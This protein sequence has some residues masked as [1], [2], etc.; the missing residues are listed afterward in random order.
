ME[1]GKTARQ[2]RGTDDAG[3]LRETLFLDVPYLLDSLFRWTE[4]RGN[5][6]GSVDLVDPRRPFVRQSVH[7]WPFFWLCALVALFV[8]YGP[9]FDSLCALV[10][11]KGFGAIQIVLLVGLYALISWMVVFLAASLLTRLT[12]RLRQ[13]PALFDA[14]DR[15][16]SFEMG[17]LPKRVLSAARSSARRSILTRTQVDRILLVLP[18][19]ATLATAMNERGRKRLA[20]GLIAAFGIVAA[21]VAP[22]GAAFWFMADSQPDTFAC[23]A[24]DGGGTA[25]V[26]QLMAW[27]LCVGAAAFCLSRRPWPAIRRLLVL[28]VSWAAVVAV[29]WGIA[30]DSGSRELQPGPYRHFFPLVVAAVVLVACVSWWLAR[31]LFGR[32]AVWHGSAVAGETTGQGG[33]WEQVYRDRLASTPLIA[34]ERHDPPIERF[35]ILSAI[36]NGAGQRP[37]QALLLPAFVA[38]TFP[39]K[40]LLTWT[41]LAALVALILLAYGTLSSRW[42]AMVAYI[43]RSFLVGTPLPVSLL[44]VVLG[45]LRLLDVQYVSTLL[46]AAPFGTIFVLLVM[47]YAM[48]W[49]FEHWVNRWPAE[50]LLRVLGP[51]SGECPDTITL[52]PTPTAHAGGAEGS[53]RY[54][55]LHGT[56]R[57][58]AQGWFMRSKP[59]PWERGVEAMFSTYSMSELFKRLSHSDDDPDAMHGL[60]RRLRFYFYT[61]NILVVLAAFGLWQWHSAFATPLASAP[62][63]DVRVSHPEIPA[64]SNLLEALRARGTRPALIV[65]ASGGGTRAALYTTHALEGIARLGRSEDVVLVSGVS[66]GGVAAAVYVDRF[67]VLSKSQDFGPA[68]PWARYREELSQPFI[69]DVLD[70]IGE[71]RIAGSTPLGKLLGESFTRRLFQ[72]RLIDMSDLKGPLLILNTTVSGHPAENSALL[73]G[74]AA[75]PM[76]SENSND[77]CSDISRP[78]SSLSGARLI[79]TTLNSSAGFPAGRPDLPDVTLP[80]VVLSA[81]AAQPGEGGAGVPAMPLAEAAALNANFPPVFPNARV[82]VRDAAFPGCDRRSYFVTDGGAT[83]NL[84]L[85]SALYALRAAVREASVEEALPPLHLIAVEASAVSYD[86][87]ADRGI[88]AATGGSKERVNGAL[89]QELIAGIERDLSA[90]GKGESLRIHYLPLPA[91]FRSRGGLGTHWMYAKSFRVSNPLVAEMPG[92]FLSFWQGRV[93][94]SEPLYEMLSQDDILV[95]WTALFD[96]EGRFCDKALS[97][98]QRTGHDRE[99]IVEWV[100]PSPEALHVREWICGRQV[101]RPDAQ[102]DW[103]IEAWHALVNELN[104]SSPINAPGVRAASP[105]KD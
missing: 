30:T 22:F 3:V 93:L 54:L 81:A 64:E 10:G 41:F 12:R 78:F 52:P 91:A 45:V 85:I 72:D 39:T 42:Q 17:D 13:V 16:A 8:I 48:T 98:V 69:T 71:L 103:Q 87:R 73:A 2:E 75:L 7:T 9:T 82:R 74:R 76:P 65:A 97:S 68:G 58:C 83:E 34:N 31:I 18:E 37:L 11:P 28:G 51:P 102:A 36:V 38:L 67:G 53:G 95:L 4:F 56:G 101:E 47:C 15:M 57:F 26:A 100:P 61:V 88:G 80:F 84:G 105:V 6:V 23:R 5:R 49:F 35:R 40:G 29:Y 63:V 94:G 96:G 55:S 90:R 77:T 20:L 89:T 14:E 25:V 99:R 1:Q 46:D 79:F 92:R 60:E 44:V 70:G 66:G 50:H 86:Y 59:S 104:T 19:I 24:V 32:S 21:A 62:V 43:E 33:S 27:I